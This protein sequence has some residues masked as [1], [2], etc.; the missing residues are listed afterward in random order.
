MAAKTPKANIEWNKVPAS[1]C[2]E[3][4]GKFYVAHMGR[5]SAVVFWGGQD[6]Q[7]AQAELWARSRDGK[8]V[9]ACGAL[10][11]KTRP[12]PGL[13]GRRRRRR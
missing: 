12:L 13:S 4:R 7:R 3:D 1:A 11:R 5:K 9:R 8:N 6:A 2:I 10:F